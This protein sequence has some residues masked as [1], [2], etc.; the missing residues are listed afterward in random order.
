[1]IRNRASISQPTKSVVTEANMIGARSRSAIIIPTIFVK[2]AV[3]KKAD[4]K[5]PLTHVPLDLCLK[6]ET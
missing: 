3:A 4:H 5:V 6:L 2:C 1:M